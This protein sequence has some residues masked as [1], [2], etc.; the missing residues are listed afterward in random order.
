MGYCS[1]L[2]LDL[3]RKYVGIIQFHV[4]QLSEITRICVHWKKIKLPPLLLTPHSSSL[5][6][7]S[8]HHEDHFFRLDLFLITKGWSTSQEQSQRWKLTKAFSVHS[9]KQQ[10]KD[11][12]ML[13][14]LWY[15]RERKWHESWPR[16]HLFFVRDQYMLIIEIFLH[17]QQMRS[18]IQR[19]HR[20]VQSSIASPLLY[21]PQQTKKLHLQKDSLDLL[22]ELIV[23]LIW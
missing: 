17:V 16:N 7:N 5:N 8:P 22:D 13:T 12:R 18:S 21:L 4:R 9:Y 14:T 15:F 19:G 6:K 20:G 2:I 23:Q 1:F 3:S 10:T 11:S